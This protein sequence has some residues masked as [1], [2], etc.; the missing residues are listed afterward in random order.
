MKVKKQILLKDIFRLHFYKQD[1]MSIYLPL[2]ETYKI[3][4]GFS[5]VKK[6][7]YDS[8]RL[9]LIDFDTTFTK[10]KLY[11]QYNNIGLTHAS[12]SLH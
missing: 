1:L 3:L 4:C 10:F 9:K 8:S 5:Q 12:N 6:P 2:V 11:V 7:S